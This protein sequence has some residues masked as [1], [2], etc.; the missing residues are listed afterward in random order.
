MVVGP[1]PYAD[2]VLVGGR[3]RRHPAVGADGRIV[4]VCLP[5]RRLDAL[6]AADED[7]LFLAAKGTFGS[8]TF[9]PKARRPTTSAASARALSVCESTRQDPE[10]KV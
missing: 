8:F 9:S 10:E 3:Q 5:G 2:G 7:G 6:A 4:C 1:P